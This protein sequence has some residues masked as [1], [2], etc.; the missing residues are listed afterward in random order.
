VCS[1]RLKTVF[2][3]VRN[4]VTSPTVPICY[5]CGSAVAT[6]HQSRTVILLFAGAEQDRADCD[7]PRRP[8]TAGKKL[9][10]RPA[11]CNCERSRE[12]AFYLPALYG[13]GEEVC[14]P[15]PPEARASSS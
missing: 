9:S 1:L 7:C 13:S 5:C 6:F 15:D 12:G 2:I 11:V 14:E 10:N 8:A 3:N 4:S